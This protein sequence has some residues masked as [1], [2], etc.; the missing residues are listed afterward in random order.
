MDKEIKPLV[1]KKKTPVSED[2]SNFESYAGWKSLKTSKVIPD[3]A[4]F[5][6]GSLEGRNAKLKS[7]IKPNIFVQGYRPHSSD[8]L[9][10]GDKRRYS[11]I[12]IGFPVPK[13]K[14]EEDLFL[15]S[16][17]LYKAISEAEFELIFLDGEWLI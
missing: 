12:F 1:G 11:Q 5:V 2:L 13:V 7:D 17:N 4:Y 14:K 15:V 8:E 10:L 9:F 3:G 6:V 16:G